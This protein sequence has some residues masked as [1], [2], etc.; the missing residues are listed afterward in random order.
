MGIEN[1]KFHKT[2]ELSGGQQQ[3]V[4]IARSLINNPRIILADE[5]TGNLDTASSQEIINTLKK[6]NDEG[7]TVV[8]VTH[9]E[10][11]AKQAKRIIR[12]RDGEITS[13]TLGSDTNH[14][15]CKT[16]SEIDLTSKSKLTLMEIFDYITH[17]FKTLAANKVRTGLSILGILIGVAAVIAMLALGSGAKKAIEQQLSSLGS[18]L[19]MLRS[20]ASIW[21]ALC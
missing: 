7:I 1:R 19:L 6:L 2:N 10:D 15:T 20:G 11:I 5:P 17:G 4:A 16:V 9:E 12:M 14:T 3:R 21:A 8:L 18:N 13:D